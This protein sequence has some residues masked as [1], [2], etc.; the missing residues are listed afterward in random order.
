[1]HVPPILFGRKGRIVQANFH[2]QAREAQSESV[3]DGEKSSAQ[4][5]QETDLFL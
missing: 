2:K 4:L 3:V 1:M 5:E